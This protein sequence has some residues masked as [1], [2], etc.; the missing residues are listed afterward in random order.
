MLDPALCSHFSHPAPSSN[1]VYFAKRRNRSHLVGNPELRGWNLFP[2]FPR[3][4]E[5]PVEVVL[6]YAECP[7]RRPAVKILNLQLCTKLL[8]DSLTP[9]EHRLCQDPV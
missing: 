2:V 9:D 7:P 3:L 4:V 8:V 6:G 1:D 5:N